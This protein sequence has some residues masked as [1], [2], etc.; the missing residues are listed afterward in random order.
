[1]VKL[2]SN[3]KI[4]LD[5]RKLFDI[6]LD[7]V[8]NLPRAYKFTIGSKMEDL[9]VDMIHEVAAAYINKDAAETLKHLTELQAKFETLKLLIRTAGEREWIKGKGR[10]AML[11]ELMDSI[12]K[13]SSAWKNAVLSRMA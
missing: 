6:I 5:T 8:P 11:V 1:M 4:Y 12:G 2:V 10:L 13:Q 9:S 3:T 7:T